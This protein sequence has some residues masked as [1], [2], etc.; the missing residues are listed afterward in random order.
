VGDALRLAASDSLRS[1]DSTLALQVWER[2]IDELRLKNEAMRLQHEAQR[3]AFDENKLLF[4][5]VI[6]YGS[7]AL[8]S[9]L[10]LNGGA[11]IALLALTG[12]LVSN[13]IDPSAI[14]DV[15]WA[16]LKFGFGALMGAGGCGL[17]YLTQYGYQ[18]G[19]TSRFWRWTAISLHVGTV[20]LVIAGYVTFGVALWEAAFS[21][22]H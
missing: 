16:I 14:R 9:L 8:R 2:E 21:I 6:T 1:G 5:S 3:L 11:A 13:G 17:A 10:I 19:K 7:L 22:T 4:D 12:T 20:A 15:G 18:M